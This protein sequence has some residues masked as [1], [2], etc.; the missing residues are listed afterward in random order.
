MSKIHK[1]LKI[2]LIIL[3][4]FLFIKNLNYALLSI[5]AIS[6]HELAHILILNGDI[7]LGLS[8]LGFKIDMSRKSYIEKEIFLYVSGS[9]FNIL[10][11][12]LCLLLISVYKFYFLYEFMI[13]N[14]VIGI[15]N[16]IPAFPLDGAVIFKNLLFV[17]FSRLK[18]GFVSIFVSFFVAIVLLII[19]V[20]LMLVFSFINLTYIVI[21]LFIFISTYREYKIF[22]CTFSLIS[23]DYRKCRFLKRK[24]MKTNV[25]SLSYSVNL[26]DVIKLY[27]FNKFSVF[28][29]VDDDLKII[30]VMNEFD[31]LKNYKKFGNIQIKKFYE[32]N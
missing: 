9:L 30:G 24:F 7:Y 23:V 22:M 25:I 27:K 16:L 10:I 26:L 14:F 21:V 15:I 19:Y 4:F 17:K 20:Y 31:I 6:L 18:A 3:Y 28:Y 11:G 12:F 1:T 2:G 5:L 32:N 8:V 13:V 29:F